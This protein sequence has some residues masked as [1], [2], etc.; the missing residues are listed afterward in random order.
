MTEIDI[1][2]NER[3]AV[4]PCLALRPEYQ[5]TSQ[6]IIYTAA[7]PLSNC[8]RSECIALLRILHL[9]ITLSISF[10]LTLLRGSR[11][12]PQLRNIVKATVVILVV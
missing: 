10:N 5:K 2:R 4:L 1:W 9:R 7:C 11:N 6:T 8:Y 3:M 12:S